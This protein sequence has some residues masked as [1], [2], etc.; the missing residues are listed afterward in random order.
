MRT[1][2][3]WTGKFRLESLK[4]TNKAKAQGWIPEPKECRRCKQNKGIIHLHNEDY[5]V[6]YYTLREV[7]D[8]FPISITAKEIEAVNLVLEPLCWRCHM[9]HHSIRRNKNAVTQYFKEIKD[10]KQYPPIFK[11]DFTIL[12]RDHN[13]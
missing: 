4:L 1:Y 13:V 2:K 10:G 9:M 3:N 5:D 7:F 12:K 8:R 6:T 11:H